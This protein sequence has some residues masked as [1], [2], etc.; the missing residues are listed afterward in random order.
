LL[1]VVKAE[2]DPPGPDTQSPLHRVQLADIPATRSGDKAIKAIENATLGQ[3]G[4]AAS[5]PDARVA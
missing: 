3:E 4:R 1:L 5:D 2:A